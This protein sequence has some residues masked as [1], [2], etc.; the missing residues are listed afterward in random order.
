MTEQAEESI[1]KSIKGYFIKTIIGTIV[2]LVVV[3]VITSFT[4]YIKSQ[5]KFDTHDKQINVISTT[6]DEHTKL[7]NTFSNK[8]G[9]NDFQVKNINKRMDDFEA[10]Q[11]EMYNLMIQ[12]AADQKALLRTK[13]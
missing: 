3:I 9:I 10:R 12:I 5:D 4:F 11:N 1:T 2:S 13:K 8:D 6:L 7:L